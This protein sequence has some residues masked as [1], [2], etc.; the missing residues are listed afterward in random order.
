MGLF[1]LSH[2]F[3]T[4]HKKVWLNIKFGRKS[5]CFNPIQL[6]GHNPSPPPSGLKMGVLNDK[7]ALNRVC[8]FQLAHLLSS[9]AILGPDFLFIFWGGG[10]LPPGPQEYEGS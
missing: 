10:G 6:G 2:K 4:S 8:K 9:G 5:T 3:L 1:F 7:I